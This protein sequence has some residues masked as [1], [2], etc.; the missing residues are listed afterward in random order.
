M[1]PTQKSTLAEWFT[2]PRGA[3]ILDWERRQVA[4]AVEDVFGF[5]AV[6]VG[7]P[8]IDFLAENRMPFRFRAGRE[9]GCELV[10]EAGALPIASA[11]VDLVVLPHVLEFSANPH[12]ILREAE[13]VLMP[14]GQLVV[15]GFNPL[16]LWGAKRALARRRRDYPWRGDFIGLLRLRDWLKLLGFELNGGKFGCYAPPFANAAWLRRSAF[17]EKAGDRWWPIAGGVYVVRAVKR[18]AGMRLVTP[19]WKNNGARAKVLAPVARREPRAASQ[20]TGRGAAELRL[21]VGGREGGE[22]RG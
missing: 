20:R 10:A 13:R 14:E 17:L 3:Y 19:A 8:E 15:S 7:L 21:V 2:T 6:Q 18:V 1:E 9:P 11:S 4:A 22:R 5:R 12:Q 16:S